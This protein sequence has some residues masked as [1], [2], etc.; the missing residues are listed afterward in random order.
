MTPEHR[1]QTAFYGQVGGA[2]ARPDFGRIRHGGKWGASGGQVWGKSRA[3]PPTGI[4]PNRSD[5]PFQNHEN[6]LQQKLF[7]ELWG[8]VGGQRGASPGQVARG[9]SGASPATGFWRLE[10]DR[11]FQDHENPLQQKLFGE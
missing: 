11:P 8:Q 2:V 1:P 9:K 3:S 7:G 4:W 6:P 5:R 10:S